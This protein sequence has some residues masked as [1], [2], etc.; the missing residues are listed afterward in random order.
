M[1]NHYFILAIYEIDFL[2]YWYTLI[3]I[4]YLRDIRKHCLRLYEI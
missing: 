4:R 3:K 2:L 1:I